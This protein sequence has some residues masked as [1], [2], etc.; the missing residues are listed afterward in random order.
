MDLVYTQ[1]EKDVPEWMTRVSGIK[2]L[3]DYL[4]QEAIEKPIETIVVDHITES[5]LKKFSKSFISF[6][7]CFQNN[8][9]VMTTEYT[10]KGNPIML[11][12]VIKEYEITDK[13]LNK[14]DNLSLQ[15]VGKIV[16]LD[17]FGFDYNDNKEYN[18]SILDHLYE[19][20]FLAAKDIRSKLLSRLANE[21]TDLY[22]FTLEKTKSL[23][24]EAVKKQ[25]T[26]DIESYPRLFERKTC[27]YANNMNSL[28][29]LMKLF[30]DEKSIKHLLSN[31]SIGLYSID[32]F[33]PDQMS[34]INADV[35]YLG[36]IV[37]LLQKRTDTHINLFC[38]MLK[39]I[40]ELR[41]R[42]VLDTKA[43]DLYMRAESVIWEY[44]MQLPF[45]EDQFTQLLSATGSELFRTEIA[46]ELAH[47]KLKK[48]MPLYINCYCMNDLEDTF[49]LNRDKDHIN[50]NS[51]FC[52]DD[53]DSQKGRIF[54]LVNDIGEIRYS[55]NKLWNRKD[56]GKEIGSFL[57]L[58]AEI[59]KDV[60]VDLLIH[61]LVPEECLDAVFQRITR[62]K[63]CIYMRPL[64]I[65]YKYGGLQYDKG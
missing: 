59:I 43:M 65:A 64:L 39:M 9:F 41:R 60:F 3:M 13:L 20:E 62:N 32:N 52:R 15:S 19:P 27:L 46:Y 54:R 36:S 63:K 14:I 57:T 38:F 48:K 35:K 31:N 29:F 8:L 51:F 5:D 53:V 58:N 18:Y 44:F 24:D 12:L 28:L 22:D 1:R 6:V 40:T 2:G 61:G 37:K 4:E 34:I 45:E 23:N 49:G 17:A 21:A 33:L 7:E 47:R 42:S 56:L 50:T 11:S 16:Q 26:H 30:T 25:F 10:I 55:E